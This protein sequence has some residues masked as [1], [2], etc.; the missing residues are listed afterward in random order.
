MYELLRAALRQRPEY[1]LVGEV[2]GKEALT[3]FQA[4]STGHVTYS[5][6]HADSV[7]SV[8]HRLENPPLSVP[9]NMLSALKLVSVQV[10]ARVGGQRIRRNKQLIEILDIDPR[11]NELITNE[12]FRWNPSTDEIRYSG[13]SFILEEIMED[14]GWS[15]ARM[16]EELKRR[17][18]LL[19]W[20]RLKMIRHYTDVSKMLISYFRDPEAVIK[21]VR[22]DLYE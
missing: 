15:E 17:Q 9:R 19:E 2:R 5:T 22:Q 16:R 12:V 14:R 18:E 21:L 6:M 1:L 7:A 8:V 4:M 10:Q 20:M 13:K 3:L 11:T